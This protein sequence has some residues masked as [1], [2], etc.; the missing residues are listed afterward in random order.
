MKKADRPQ[1]NG[2][3]IFVP[4]DS[5]ATCL[6]CGTSWSNHGTASNHCPPCGTE[7][8]QGKGKYKWKDYCNKTK[9][10]KGPCAVVL[11]KRDWRDSA[12]AWNL[13]QAETMTKKRKK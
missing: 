12:E 11:G 4:V 1:V 13:I 10:H 8:L 5:N 6:V 3:P 9:R 2:W 7:L